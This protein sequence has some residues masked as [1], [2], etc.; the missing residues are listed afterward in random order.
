MTQE[1]LSGEV[2]AFTID[3]NGEARPL[4]LDAARAKQVC[5]LLIPVLL[6]TCV[7]SCE[8]LL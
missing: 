1:M 4:E 3:A 6:A 7:L 5:S 8:M 2:V